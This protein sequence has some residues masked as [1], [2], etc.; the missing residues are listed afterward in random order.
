MAIIVV[1]SRLGPETKLRVTSREAGFLACRHLDRPFCVAEKALSLGHD[2]KRLKH[3]H[4]RDTDLQSRGPGRAGSK[5]RNR[6]NSG[7]KLLARGFS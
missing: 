7:I 4:I 2:I 3:S 6:Y 5:V 1:P